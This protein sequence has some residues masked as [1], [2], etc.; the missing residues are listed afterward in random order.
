MDLMIGST[1][2]IGR[3]DENTWG[4]NYS[5]SDWGFISKQRRDLKSYQECIKKIQE[6]E[7]D[8]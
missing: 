7:N 6:W 2:A 4:V 1:V 8:K 5:R 3:I